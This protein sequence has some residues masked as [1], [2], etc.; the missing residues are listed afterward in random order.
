MK[1]LKKLSE[2]VKVIL[3]ENPEARSDDDYL[4]LVICRAV[5]PSIVAL[6]FEVVMAHRS[7]CGLPSYK[8]VERARR[9]IQRAYP[10][11]AADD[12]IEGYRKMKE[13]EFINYARKKTV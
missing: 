2:L 7:E 4:Y 5:K 10:E 1:G 12:T 8:S 11:L 13:E 9:K 6:P 3:T